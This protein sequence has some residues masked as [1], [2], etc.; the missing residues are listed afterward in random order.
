[1]APVN[2]AA[3]LV[4]A[5]KP[6][7]L[8]EA[9][10]PVPAPNEIVIS[11]RAIAI[12][13]VDY[14]TQLLGTNIFPWLKFPT[15]I[16]HDVA[17]EVVAVGS[18]VGNFKAGD[19]V[20][21]L[22]PSA[23]QAYPTL[24]AYT[25]S[26]IPDSITYE[27]A[28]VIPL[29]FVTAGVGL[30]RKDY[31]GLQHPSVNATPTGKTLL[32]WAASTSVGSCA[33]QLA[34]SAG[35]EVITT[36]SPKNFAYAKNLGASHVFDY[37]SPTVQEDIIAAFNGKESAGILAISGVDAESRAFV[38]GAC[39]H[40]AEKIGGNKFVAFAAPPPE[41]LPNG[42]GAKFI[43]SLDPLKDEVSANVLFRD[44]LTGALA[45]GKFRPA[46][47]PEVVGEGLESIQGAMDTLQKGVSAKKLVVRI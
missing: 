5:Q 28:S 7:E 42:V 18:A 22:T 47:D 21:G 6:L 33:V 31:L 24:P 43:M 32:I 10:Y 8:K 3:Y 1:M 30:F 27:R 26:H 4:E 25:A 2:T 13:P 11:N 39:L 23:F 41:T 17:G 9:P 40:I 16:G 45:A 46:P 35:Y 34:V 15:I 12:N 19:R 14:A 38:G 37:R 29:G 44:Y 20:V 36:A